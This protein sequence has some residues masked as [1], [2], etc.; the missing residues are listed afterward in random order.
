METRVIGMTKKGQNYYLI[1]PVTGLE[2]LLND[3]I[4]CEIRRPQYSIPEMVVFCKLRK[5]NK[6]I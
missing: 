4:F 5:Q 1:C 3:C 6:E 2:I